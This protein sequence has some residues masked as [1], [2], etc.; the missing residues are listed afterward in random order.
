MGQRDPH[1]M[2][3]CRIAA[4]RRVMACAQV[5]QVAARDDP[6]RRI[7]RHRSVE[8]GSRVVW[9]WLPGAQ[10]GFTG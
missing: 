9:L 2:Q 5:L 6:E 1:L 3:G 7:A 4:A 10:D 8:L